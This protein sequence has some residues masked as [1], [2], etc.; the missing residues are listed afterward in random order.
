[1][2]SDIPVVAKEGFTSGQVILGALVGLVVI[3]VVNKLFGRRKPAAPVLRGAGAQNAAHRSAAKGEGDAAANASSSSFSAA[4][5]SSSAPVEVFL[6]QTKQVVRLTSKTALSHDTFRFRFNLPAPDLVLGLPVGKH[7]KIYG[8][9]DF[10]PAK[11][12]EW[13]GQ[14]DKEHGKKEITRS[15]TPVTSDRDLG[16]FIY[17]SP[18]FPLFP[19]PRINFF[20]K[21][22]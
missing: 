18:L 11:E 6:N 10:K 20:K 7:F 13:N 19:P 14:P 9:N 4:S 5:S 16:Y 8:P 21:I 22:F 3:F 2:S 17:F 12:G 15:Y 1:M